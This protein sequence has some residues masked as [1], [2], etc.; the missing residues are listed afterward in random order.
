MATIHEIN[1]VLTGFPHPV[2]WSSFHP[3][4][5]SPTPPLQAHLSS[6]Y[7][8]GTWRAKLDQGAYRV[9]GFRITVALVGSST[10]AV[11]AA[12][13]NPALLRHEQGHYDITGLIAR[14][15]ARNLLDLELDATV[16][17]SLREAGTTAAQHLHYAQ[18]QL[19]RSVD[20]E[21][22]KAAALLNRLQTNPTTRADG[23]YDQQTNHGLNQAAQSTWNTLLAAVKQSNED[24]G[25]RLVIAGIA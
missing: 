24:F 12:R 3:V 21:G 22:R 23:I 17:A 6:S 15:L 4:N 7:R 11:A 25:F 1:A 14:D 13:S 16:V 9:R 8:M 18:Q 2:T 5:S 20:E 19:Q 10:W